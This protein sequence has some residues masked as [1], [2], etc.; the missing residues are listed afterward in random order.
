[1]L[2]LIEAI[3]AIATIGINLVA[4]THALSGS[5]TRRLTLA[6]IAGG[7]AGLAIGLGY[8]GRF[9]FSPNIPFPL[10]GVFFAAPLLTVGVLALTR[11]RVRAALL[12]IPQHLLIGLNS[13]RILG[14]LFLFEYVR[15]ALSG[16]FP[17]FAGIGDIITGV[18]AI[19]LALQVARS[20]NVSASAIARWNAFGALDLI[21]AVGLGITSA[22]GSPL[23]LIHA[24][25]G[26]QAI[27]YLPL[28]L[29]PTVLVPYYLITHGIV[30]AQLRVRSKAAHRTLSTNA[31]SDGTA[32]QLAR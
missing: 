23:Q 27:Q 4:I 24:G 19:P 1:M 7:W 2:N 13:L 25:V 3:T 30:A 29:V 32:S 28:C 8:A 17:F 21:V 5:L 10:I 11:D 14:V 31:V 9:A 6:A 16:P 26:S 20:Q 22:A 12:G 15:G 18:V